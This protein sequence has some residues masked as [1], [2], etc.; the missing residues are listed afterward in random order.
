[1]EDELRMPTALERL[2]AE[3]P[4]ELLR[5]IVSDARVFSVTELADAQGIEKAKDAFRLVPCNPGK[6][7]IALILEI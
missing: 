4:I 6:L 5:L 7:Y 2:M 1:M 3:N